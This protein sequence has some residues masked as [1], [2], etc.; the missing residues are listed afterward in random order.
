MLA[1]NKSRSGN[2]VFS[3]HEI[4]DRGGPLFG[5]FEQL[6]IGYSYP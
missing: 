3:D 5:K 4:R 6:L 1:G 2:T